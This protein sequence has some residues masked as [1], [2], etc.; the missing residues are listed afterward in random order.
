MVMIITIENEQ[1]VNKMDKA[2]EEMRKEFLLHG[3]KDKIIIFN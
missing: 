1:V 3:L 2:E